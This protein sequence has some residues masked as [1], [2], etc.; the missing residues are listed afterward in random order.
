M[1]NYRLDLAYL[2]TGFHGYASQPNLRTVQGELEAALER[3][4]GPVETVVAGRTDKGVHAAAQVVSF[5]TEHAVDCARLARSLNTQLAPAIAVLALAPAPA[6]FHARFSATGRAYRYRV[7]NREAPDPFLAA[8]TYHYR[9]SLELGAMQQAGQALLGNH[10]F[11]SFC[12][13]TPGRS[14]TRVL[15]TIEWAE[16][17]NGVKEL[18]IAASSFCHQMVRSIVAVSL[19]IGRGKLATSAMAEILEARDREAGRGAAPPH[20][21]TLVAVEY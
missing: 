18:Y 19:D 15:R 12:R 4:I 17:A 11:A 9:T 10:D 14:T 20:G 7:L 8:T 16:H 13:A 21:L 3:V 6:D 1:G 5:H 2:G